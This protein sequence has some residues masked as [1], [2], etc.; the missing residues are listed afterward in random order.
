MQTSAKTTIY[1]AAF[2]SSFR[3]YGAGDCRASYA[4]LSEA[5]ERVEWPYDTGDDPSFFSRRYFGGQLTWGICRQQI[6]TRIQPGDVVVFFSFRNR[7]GEPVEYRLGAVATVERKVSQ[8]DLWNKSEGSGYWRR[9]LN[10]LIR[11]SHFGGWEHYEKGAPPRKWHSDWA[12]RIADHEKLQ[13]KHF[14]SI[15]EAGVI[16]QTTRVNGRPFKIAQNYVI[17]S[18]KSSETYVLNN[19]PIVAWC[20]RPE[21]WEEWND[22]ALSGAIKKRTVDLS[23]VYGGRGSLRTRNPWRPHPCDS[24]EMPASQAQAWRG[25]FIRFLRRRDR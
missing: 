24:W 6:R 14:K 15:N 17:F 20:E 4:P 18:G 7:D 8:A 12:W 2:H 9:Y 22:D 21:R 23:L 5:L 3:G 11:Q 19:P 25:E 10:L 1:L 16:S 13:K